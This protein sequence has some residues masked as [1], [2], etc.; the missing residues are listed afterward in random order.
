MF[1]TALPS[2]GNFQRPQP[3]VSG[4]SP[5]M[6]WGDDPVVFE[7]GSRLCKGPGPQNHWPS[8]SQDCIPRERIYRKPVL[9]IYMSP[10]YHLSWVFVYSVCAYIHPMWVQM[11]M[12]VYGSWSCCLPQFLCTPSFETILLPEWLGAESI[13]SGT[14]LSHP[15][16]TAAGSGCGH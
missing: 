14:L 2:Q 11:R 9:C 13:N 1:S 12:H 15:E 10:R 4:A 5:G 7:G 16:V 3:R 6:S 8:W